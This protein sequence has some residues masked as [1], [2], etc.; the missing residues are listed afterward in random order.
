[1]RAST[2]L[3][4]MGGLRAVL[5]ALSA[6]LLL[7]ALGCNP[8]SIGRPCINPNQNAASGTQVSSP[9][10]E[11]PSRLCLIQA[12]TDQTSTSQ[13]GSRNT[14][15]AGCGSDGDC[16]AETKEYC[17]AGF[18]CAVATQVGSFCCKKLCVCATDLVPGFNVE[19][20]P[21]DPADPQIITPHACDPLSGAI[22]TCKNVQQ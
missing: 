22:I 12:T 21:V 1:M 20:Q 15:T 17:A 4:A 11:C 18:K 14:C 19:S 13:D 8:N 16:D 3:R 6:V 5:G 9:A 7:G 2:T 10:L